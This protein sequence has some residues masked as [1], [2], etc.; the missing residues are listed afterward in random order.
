VAASLLDYYLTHGP[1]TALGSFAEQ[2]DA[3][4]GDVGSI[5]HAVQMLVVHRAWAK[6]YIVTT[7]IVAGAAA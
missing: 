2:V 1:F 7:S 4:P 5:A 6:A 3:L